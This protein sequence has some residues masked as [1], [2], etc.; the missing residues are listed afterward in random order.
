[1]LIFCSFQ[2]SSLCLYMTAEAN[3]V[4]ASL[5][6]LHWNK[7]PVVSLNL[8]SEDSLLKT[9]ACS[10]WKVTKITQ[11]LLLASH[12]KFNIC[13]ISFIM[14]LVIHSQMKRS[15][16]MLSPISCIQYR[17]YWYKVHQKSTMKTKWK[18]F[19]ESSLAWYHAR[20]MIW[21]GSFIGEEVVHRGRG[22]KGWSNTWDV[23]G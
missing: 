22:T 15:S 12:L 2:H 16:L 1:M 21:Y 20:K 3:M 18:P 17:S 14:K 23:C 19:R 9:L 13:K 8:I 7:K 4:H 5:V 6:S 11:V 10:Q